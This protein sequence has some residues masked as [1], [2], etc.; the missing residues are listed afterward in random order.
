MRLLIR[1]LDKILDKFDALAN[2]IE[3]RRAALETIAHLTLDS[4]Q[5]NFEEEGRP[6]HWKPLSAATLK[7]R[8]NKRKTKILQDTGYLK[9]HINFKIFRNRVEIRANAVYAAIQHFGGFAGKGHKVFIPARPYLMLQKQD[10]RDI[11]EILRD[12]L[13]FKGE[14]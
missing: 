10:E 4:I 2:R 11:H 7:A 3:N 12:Y 5:K 6:I 14:A 9:S 13:G 8:R 1:N